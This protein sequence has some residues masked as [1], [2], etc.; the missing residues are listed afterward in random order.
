MLDVYFCPRVV[1]RLRAGPDAPHLEAFTAFLHHRGHTRNTI[2]NYVRA[3]ETFVRWLRRRRQPLDSVTEDVARAFACRGRPA[4]R[5]RH[6]THAAL[7]LLLCHLRDA[8]IVPPRHIDTPNGIA[9]VVA[10]Y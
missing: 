2:H 8:G 6:G 1:S 5:P 3:A 10:E 4:Q 9:Q 7:R